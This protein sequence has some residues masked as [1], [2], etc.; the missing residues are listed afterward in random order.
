M[1][2]SAFSVLPLLL[3]SSSL[4]GKKL[5]SNDS[6]GRQHEQLKKQQKQHD[7]LTEA[8]RLVGLQYGGVKWFAVIV[9]QASQ[10]AHEW[11]VPEDPLTQ[12]NSADDP[13]Y[14]P[15]AFL[16]LVLTVD[17]S[18][19]RARYP[20]NGALH[21]D[22]SDL[23]DA[24]PPVAERDPSYA[25]IMNPTDMLSWIE[26]E[27]LLS[28]DSICLPNSSNNDAG[29][30]TSGEAAEVCS[31]GPDG[32]DKLQQLDPTLPTWRPEKVSDV[33]VVDMMDASHSENW[34]DL[35]S[36]LFTTE[37]ESLVDSV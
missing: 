25:A 35:G 34:S 3:H 12:D 18:L 10:L 7:L 28:G 22:L 33:E 19:S 16:R 14:S 4:Q 24:K 8:M 21:S 15:K 30:V 13:P 31:S 36:D 29:N 37:P 17:M 5:L 9:R 23:L 20:Y 32:L 26:L 27:K 1:N 11:A 6:H 2:R